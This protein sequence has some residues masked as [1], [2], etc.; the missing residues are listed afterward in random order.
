MKK[1]FVLSKSLIELA[2]RHAIKSLRKLLFKTTRISV[3]LCIVLIDNLLK[4]IK[5]L[6]DKMFYY[7]IKS[8][9]PFIKL[10]L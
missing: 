1:Q 2:S 7:L 6:G 3:S 4:D 9:F 8:L 5:Q 10:K